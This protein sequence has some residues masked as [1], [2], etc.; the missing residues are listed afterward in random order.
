MHHNCCALFS[1][2][3]LQVFGRFIELGRNETVP[4]K[5]ERHGILFMTFWKLWK[6]RDIS[7]VYVHNDHIYYYFYALAKERY[8]RSESK[9]L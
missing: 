6:R 5:V 2:E 8:I 7:G 4:D 3:M 1:H 9:W